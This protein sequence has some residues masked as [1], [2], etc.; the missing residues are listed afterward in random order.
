MDEEPGARRA[1]LSV[2]PKGHSLCRRYEPHLTSTG[3]DLQLGDSPIPGQSALWF[4]EIGGAN[5]AKPP[6]LD[7][8]KPFTIA[9]TFL[10]P[11]GDAL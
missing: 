11:K 2:R 4:A 9:V 5:V 3:V 1:S 7:A 8:E 10:S 6:K